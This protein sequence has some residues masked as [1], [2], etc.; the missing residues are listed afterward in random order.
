MLERR[1]MKCHAVYLTTAFL[2]FL[3]GVSAT[4]VYRFNPAPVPSIAV[5][6]EP[7]QKE[8]RRRFFYTGESC[9]TGFC[10]HNYE[11]SD[12][13]E[14]IVSGADNVAPKY[15]RR[16]FLSNLGAAKKTLERTIVF[17]EH[18]KRV[19]DRAVVAL[20]AKEIEQYRIVWTNGAEFWLISS[21]SLQHALEFEK[22]ELTRLPSLS[23]QSLHLTAV[24]LGL[25]GERQRSESL[26]LTTACSV[27]RTGKRLQALEAL[28]V[29][30]C[31]VANN[32]YTDLSPMSDTAN[33][34]WEG[35]D[36]ADPEQ[37]LE[38]RYDTLERWAHGISRGSRTKDGWSVVFRY[39][40][41]N[42]KFQSDKYAF[43]KYIET[44]GRVVSMDAVGDDIRVEHIDFPLRDF[45]KVSD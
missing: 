32:G 34:S 36:W 11:S 19:G 15:A 10:I 42:S 37:R 45:A 30:E 12:G 23:N 22:A 43:D 4:S 44:F 40:R 27:P 26:A 20:A 31:F 38:Y 41:T 25:A 8:V 3:V 2:T 39:N 13:I 9:G 14:L 24:R 7:F 29:A 16:H 35:V 33:L 18:G 6:H 21:P 28:R 17:D 1:I 5:T